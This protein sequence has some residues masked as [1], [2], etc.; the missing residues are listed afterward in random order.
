MMNRHSLL[1][2]NQKGNSV[3]VIFSPSYFR[4]RIVTELAELINEEGYDGPCTHA[5]MQL[6]LVCMK[7]LQQIT[8]YIIFR[9]TSAIQS[10][11]SSDIGFSLDKVHTY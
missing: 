4:R 1:R 11:K 8:R 9:S 3:W 10:D 5:L 2:V 7:T 6:A